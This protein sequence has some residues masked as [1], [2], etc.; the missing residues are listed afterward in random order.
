MLRFEVPAA[1]DVRIVLFDLGGREVAVLVNEKCQPGQYKVMWNG[2]NSM[3]IPAPTGIYF[4]RMTADDYSNT[5][6]MLL[7][8]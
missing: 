6:K 1:S 4:A 8:K 7:V 2:R 3:G 5:I